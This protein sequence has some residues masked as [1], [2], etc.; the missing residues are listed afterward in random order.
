MKK[1]GIL[2]VVAVASTTVAGWHVTQVQAF[3]PFKKEFENLYI[4][5][6]PTTDPEKSL[7]EAATGAKCGI[8]HNGPEGKDKKHRNT[9]GKA[10]EELMPKDLSKDDLD[11]LKKNAAQIKDLL[12]KAAK[13]H[14]DPKDDKSP[15]F[16]DLIKEGKLPGK[17][18]S[19][20]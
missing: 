11:A 3:P 16:G 14:S 9:Y 18:T 6:N 10:I 7:K 19:E 17:D 12:E 15:T 13:E 8:C 2:L 4:K 20:K 1:I 5:E